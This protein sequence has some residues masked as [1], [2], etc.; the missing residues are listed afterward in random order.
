VDEHRERSRRYAL[1]A[2]LAQWQKG[3][4][5]QPLKSLFSPAFTFLRIYLLKAGFLDGR[6]GWNVARVSALET[7]WRYRELEQLSRSGR[8]G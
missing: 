4:R 3:Q 7:Y 5:S 1:A 2:A 6:A 8:P